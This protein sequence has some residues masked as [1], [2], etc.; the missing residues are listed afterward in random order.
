MKLFAAMVT[1]LS[2]LASACAGVNHA[3]VA[4][5]SYALSAA[6]GKQS[7]TITITRSGSQPSR[8]APAQYFTG[9]GRLDPPVQAKEPSPPSGP[10]VPFE[11]G[12]RPPRQP[13]PPG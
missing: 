10:H 4:S 11:P 8:Q 2:L 7:E 9:P 1:S 13:H 12:G 6:S 3:K 5:R